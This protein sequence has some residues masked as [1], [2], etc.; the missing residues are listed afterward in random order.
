[1]QMVH[2]G[3]CPSYLADTVVPTAVT[4]LHSSNTQRYIQPR[5]S[6]EFGDLSFSSNGPRIWNN[7]PLHYITDTVK[8]KRFLK[9]HFLI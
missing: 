9:L 7:V 6:T 3:Q 8:F 4:G 2:T 1:M 5:V